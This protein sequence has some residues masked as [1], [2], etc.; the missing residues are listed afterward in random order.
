MLRSLT[1]CGTVLALLAG[2]VL[3]PHTHIHGGAGESV[4]E[5]HDGHVTNGALAH[6]HLDSHQRAH[7]FDLGRPAISVG[8]ESGGDASVVVA[9]EFVSH[10][11]EDGLRYPA[12]LTLVT[13]SAVASAHAASITI[14]P[15]EPPAHG[16]PPNRPSAP[17]APPTL[18]PAA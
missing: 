13:F 2:F 16:P 6:A 9:D 12:P 11:A 15:L 1:A 8:H 7:R 14:D 18:L 10:S 4:A 17:R 3:A 5:L